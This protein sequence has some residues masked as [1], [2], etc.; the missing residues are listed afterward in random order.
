MA[1]DSA[2]ESETD[3]EE[4]KKFELRDKDI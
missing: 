1:G 4:K 3:A 2:S